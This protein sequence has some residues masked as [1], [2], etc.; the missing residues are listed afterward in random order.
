MYRDK[1]VSKNL[2]NSLNHQILSGISI[3]VEICPPTAPPIIPDNNK[4][5]ASLLLI[6][7]T[8]IMYP[9]TDI[10]LPEAFNKLEVPNVLQ[11]DP[12]KI[13]VNKDRWI[14]EW[15]NAY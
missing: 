3:N 15:L 1:I 8:N 9:V 13:N 6:P 5:R 10:S 12:K 2:I 7:L 11:L 14:N 4:G